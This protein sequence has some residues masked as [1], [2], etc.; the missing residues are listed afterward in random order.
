MP[1]FLLLLIALLLISRKPAAQT[2]EAVVLQDPGALIITT[3]VEH[4]KT[5]RPIPLD[6]VLRQPALFQKLSTKP[7]FFSGWDPYFYWFRFAVRNPGP[8]PQTS[9]LL[10]GPIGHQKACLYQFR[11]GVWKEVACT[12]NQLSFAQRPLP[13]IHTAFP[14][15][16]PPGQTDTFYMS[17]DYGKNY[18][19]FAFALLT[20]RKL[21]QLESKVYFLFGLLTGVLL[22][23]GVL[24]LYLFYSLKEKI[25]LWYTAYILAL[26]F[27]LLKYEGFDEQ[28]FPLDS[29]KA[30]RLTPV[31]AI[32]G[33]TI[34][35][36]MNVVQ[37]FLSNI[38]PRS[39]LFR[40]TTLVKYNLLL[41]AITHIIVFYAQADLDAQI[42]AFEWA[43]KSTFLAI[44]LIL[45]N[46]IVSYARKFKP[47]LF[48]LVGISIFLLG[49]LQK[50]LFWDSTSYLFPPSLFE[51]GMVVEAGII[52]FGLMY[53]YSLFKKEKE[54]LESE[55]AVQNET[56]ARKVLL[57]QEVE[58]KRIAEDLHD[59]LGSSL[60]AL[61]MRLQRTGLAEAELRS[62]LPIVDRA[63]SE[64][65]TLAHNLMPP[66]FEQTSLPDLLSAY[67]R[68]MD[69]ETGV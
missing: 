23:F 52:S 35:L 38:H 11:G 44:V 17:M 19:T 27:M 26:V 24:N 30:N 36:L 9:N 47:A 21:H 59:D 69:N 40:L 15:T 10:M 5:T 22:L 3:Q 49:A 32:G 33:L 55:L 68:T 48:L 2:L 60:A 4:R 61:K 45:V 66:E 20:P 41:S 58:R 65:R 54:R 31:M 18:K 57:A 51:I 28:F 46:C 13:H 16:V 25:H 67:Y 8:D 39:L 63:A 50:I 29:A 62:L 56:A 53:R 42:A 7:V 34:F 12:G 14:L 6:S 37:R 43:N 64:V 1:Q